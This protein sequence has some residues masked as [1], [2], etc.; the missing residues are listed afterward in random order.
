MDDMELRQFLVNAK[1]ATYASEGGDGAKILEDGSRK[2]IFEEG[3]FRY[4]D[5]YFGTLPFIGEEIVW[6]D[7]VPFWG[8]NYRGR[9]VAV[10]KSALPQ[11]LNEFL[12]AA[13]REVTIEL[14]FRG[15]KSFSRGDFIYSVKMERNWINSFRGKEEIFHHCCQRFELAFHGGYIDIA[16]D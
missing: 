6:K 10:R 14:P 9:I 2:L 5:R 7:G 16:W 11:G 8:M 3:P 1:R 12:Q 15:P 13:L 4:R